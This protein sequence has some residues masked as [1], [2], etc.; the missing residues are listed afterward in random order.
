MLGRFD[1][2]QTVAKYGARLGQ[3]FSTTRA[4][5]TTVTVRTIED[6]ERNG[7]TFTDGVGKLSLFLAQMAAQDLG[8]QNTFN[9][10]PSLYQFRLGS[11]K[12]VLALDPAVKKTDVHIRPKPVQIRSAV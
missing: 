1:H 9:D 7:F 12:C 4:M 10:L 8:L 6:I 5:Q 11:C 2:I 3:Y